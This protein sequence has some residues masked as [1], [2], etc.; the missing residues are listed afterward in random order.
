[1]RQLV[2]FPAEDGRTVCGLETCESF[3]AYDHVVT[4]PRCKTY[5]KKE[6]GDAGRSEPA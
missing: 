1:M 6:A 2:H 3:T 4:C 5:E